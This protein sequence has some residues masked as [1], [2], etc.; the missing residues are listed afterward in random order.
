MLCMWIYCYAAYK[1]LHLNCILAII[2]KSQTIT[3]NSYTYALHC[4]HIT[5]ATANPSYAK[6]KSIKAYLIV[7]YETWWYLL[8]I[9]RST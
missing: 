7:M 3:S 2:K 1:I 4:R 6:Y 8:S 9:I 5:T